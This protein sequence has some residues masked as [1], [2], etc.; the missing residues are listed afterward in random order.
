MKHSRGSLAVLLVGL[1]ALVVLFSYGTRESLRQQPASSG[2]DATVSSDGPNLAT[3][4]GPATRSSVPI[5]SASGALIEV[6]LFYETAEGAR[7][8][9]FP[10]HPTMDGKEPVDPYILIRM[11]DGTLRVLPAEGGELLLPLSDFVGA[12][13]L[14]AYGPLRVR[15][16]VDG[17]ALTGDRKQAVVFAPARYAA[18]IDLAEVLVEFAP[19]EPT[20][21]YAERLGSVPP[22]PSVDRRVPL[23]DA[24]ELPRRGWVSFD[25]GPWRQFGPHCAQKTIEDASLRAARPAADVTCVLHEALESS[26]FA[27][28]TGHLVVFTR[29]DASS[30]YRPAYYIEVRGNEPV[31][32]PRYEGLGVMA[33]FY[34]SESGRV[35][36]R[37][38]V[39]ATVDAERV[40]LHLEAVALDEG[41]ATLVGTIDLRDWRPMSQVELNAAE[42]TRLPRVEGRGYALPLASKDGA[43]QVLEFELAV[44]AG[45]YQLRIPAIQLRERLRLEVGAT[46][47]VDY[48]VPR[49]V[50]VRPVVGDGEGQLDPV[51]VVSIWGVDLSRATDAVDPDRL[52]LVPGTYGGTI[53]RSAAKRVAVEFEVSKSGDVV[54]VEGRGGAEQVVAFTT[55]DGMDL[56]PAFSNLE[57]FDSAGR[58]VDADLVG[59]RAAEGDRGEPQLTSI[60]LAM[61][62]EVD[63][64]IGLL[65][66]WKPNED[67]VP[68]IW[69]VGEGV[70]PW[71]RVTVGR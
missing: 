26:W 54:V 47:A 60:R 16:A 70:G 4:P 62:P 38:E 68:S 2:A 29:P 63:A 19:E 28:R 34:E 15:Q 33:E 7:L 22:G 66:L 44:P 31:E 71:A 40:R 24:D 64:A 11:T 17:G 58:G 52:L 56:G 5:E 53:A 67:G 35:I 25:A 12:N 48:R 57:L 39:S 13:V 23:W 45:E 21:A 9:R 41:P 46:T 6:E 69:L 3:N 51:R 37:G 18:E 43:S 14:R 1:L 65:L 20:W 49:P 50:S 55:P 32:L 42:L 30:L 61:R 59:F 36:A 27:D 8:D 10:T